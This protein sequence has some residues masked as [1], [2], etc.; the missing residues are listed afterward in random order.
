M[1]RAILLVDD[2]AQIRNMIGRILTPV[3]RLAE[4]EFVVCATYAAA[5][6]AYEE[7]VNRDPP[8][9]VVLVTDYDLDSGHTGD[10]V[11]TELVRQGFTGP[12][13]MVSGRW[14]S[15]PRVVAKLTITVIAKPFEMKGLRDAVAA[16][17]AELP[18]A[19]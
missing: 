7:L 13:L 1:A 10:G 17:M 8:S 18:E 2:E 16:L 19:E 5:I 12:V 14:P 3:A 9:Q 11:I 4:A 15:E 6:A